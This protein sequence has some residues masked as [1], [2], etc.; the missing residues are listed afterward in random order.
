L[1]TFVAALTKV[2]RLAGR[3][4]PVLPLVVNK[5]L[6]KNRLTICFSKII[7]KT[8]AAFKYAAPVFICDTTKDVF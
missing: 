5:D 2:R 6:K 3:D 8:G 4:P 1:L 7:N